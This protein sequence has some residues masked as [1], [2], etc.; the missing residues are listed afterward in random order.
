MAASVPLRG[1]RVL[2]PRAWALGVRPFSRFSRQMREEGADW[3]REARRLRANVVWHLQ[4]SVRG[5]SLTAGVTS[6]ACAAVMHLRSIAFR[7]GGVSA[8]S[9]NDTVP[10]EVYS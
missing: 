9:L 10:N 4:C 1:S 7:L 6:A 5:V 8:L 3:D 2:V